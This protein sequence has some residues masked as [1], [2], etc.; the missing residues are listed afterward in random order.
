MVRAFDSAAGVAV[1]ALRERTSHQALTA[2]TNVPAVNRDPATVCENAAS[3]VLLD[4][5]APMLFN[6][7]RCVAGL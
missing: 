6:S 1:A 5:N 7:A 3:A 2:A 4:S